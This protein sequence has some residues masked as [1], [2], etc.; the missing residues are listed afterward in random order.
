MQTSDSTVG[1]FSRSYKDEA[2]LQTGL[3]RQKIS[4]ICQR[5][6]LGEPSSEIVNLVSHAT[7]E[8]L[9]TL[10]EKLNVIAEHRLDVIKPDGIYEVSQV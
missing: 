8:K 6:G 1:T 10:I 9:K 3:L 4:K 5:H 2:F 7:Q